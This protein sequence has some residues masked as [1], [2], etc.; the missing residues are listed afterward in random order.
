[1]IRMS[2]HR[3]IAATGLLFAVSTVASASSVAGTPSCQTGT[4]ASYSTPSRASAAASPG[5]TCNIGAVDVYNFQLFTL[6]LDGIATPASS[7]LLNTITINPIWDVEAQKATL[8]FQGFQN[9]PVSASETE[10][11]R[12]RYTIDPPP[13]L[14][15]ESFELDPPFGEILGSLRYCADATFTFSDGNF[16]TG[17]GGFVSF[18]F[19]DQNSPSNVPGTFTLNPPTALLDTITDIFLNPRGN[20]ASG[21]DGLVTSV[22]VTA[23]PGTIPEPG[24]WMLAAAGLLVVGRLRRRFK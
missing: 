9:F 20:R 23:D 18:G 6:S 11:Y 7:D 5:F 1:M 15:G 16:C 13:I 3:L 24:T 8:S 22:Q 2:I 14:G 19:N 4:F 12:I 17:R 10:G 21:F